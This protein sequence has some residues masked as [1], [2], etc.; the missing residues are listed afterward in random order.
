M[1]GR[2]APSDER[3]ALDRRGLGRR[4]RIALV[5]VVA[6]VGLGA[7][8]AVLAWR[9]YGDAKQ[10]ALSEAHTRVVLAATVFDTY[11]GGELAALR[12]IAAS[13]SVVSGDVPAMDAYFRRVQPRNGKLFP[14]GLGWID[15]TGRTRATSTARRGKLPNVADRGY[16]KQVMRTGRPFIS[17]GLV[18]RTQHKRV[19]VMSVPTRDASGRLTGVLAGA[20]PIGPAHTSKSAITL[21]YQGLVMVDR[22]GQ[23]LTD[24]GFA[25][26]ANTAL[27][28]RMRHRH[29]E[30]LADARGLGGAGG[31]VVTYSTSKVADWI[32]AIDRPSSAVFA[33]ARQVLVLEWVS[34]GIALLIALG[35][36]AWVY[37]RAN[38][39]AEIDRQRAL[40]TN[41][42]SR[43]LA[44]ATTHGQVADAL[45]TVLA[46][47]FDDVTSV[48][49]LKLPD[50]PQLSVCAV[51]GAFRGGPESDE[52]LAAPAVAAFDSG[53]AVVA[54]SEPAVRERFAGLRSESPGRVRSVYAEPI[55]RRGER[56]LGAV[57]LLF[58]TQRKTSETDRTRVRAFLEQAAEVFTRTIRQEREHEAAVTLQRSLLPDSLPERDGAELAVR[59][60]AGS[61]GLEV[62]GDWYDAVLRPDGFVL[63]SVG[64]VAG[65]GIRAATLMAQLRN[66]F[67]AYAFDHTSPAEIGRRLL[68]HVPEDEMVTTVT[69]SLDLYTHACAYAVSGHP[70]PLLLDGA[71]GA[72][73]RLAS[74]GSP[75][76][77]FA[78]PA[79]IVEEELTLPEQTTLLAYT[80]GLV[81]RRDTCIDDGI[82]LLA[83][84]LAENR[85]G[86]S[87]DETASRLLGVVHERRGAGFDDDAA[88]LVLRLMGIPARMEIEIP[89]D[90]GALALLRA[91]LRRW[92]EARGV[93]E[94][95]RIDAVLAIHEACINSVEHGY[96]LA[97]G[98]I[99]VVVEHGEGALDIAVED[100]GQWRPPTPDPRRGRGSVIMNA[101]MEAAT[102]H[103]DRNGTRVE[104]RQRLGREAAT[105]GV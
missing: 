48:V 54:R 97:G 57:A 50:A 98:T 58:R 78:D 79:A 37:R 41:A 105:T 18:T 12:S 68:R 67:R 103:H 91:R 88:F 10:H 4:R 62:G 52:A 104:L 7:V 75:P 59:Y 101:T 44:D 30:V 32:I 1:I 63:L 64:D 11:F 21:G 9:Q 100:Q 89:A 47:W 84:I 99:R 66:A 31:D 53:E 76:L 34:I 6:V 71:T 96:Q 42:Y 46:A 16:F 94:Q 72:V 38:R 3:D 45:A 73:T 92:L 87:A 93:G 39:N 15:S 65:R 70:P 13:P 80:D 102:V 25:R 61:A 22:R 8:A 49:A 74:S 19:V 60:Q 23:Q 95:E 27:L 77:G 28:D 51:R 43:A 17:S 26:P 20:L 40:F 5:A 82:D 33:S 36:M 69:V 86:E 35:L 90:P 55:L 2:R 81:E 83:E 24:P 14:G 56:S 29:D 85:G